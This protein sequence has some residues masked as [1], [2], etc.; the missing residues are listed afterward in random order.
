[1]PVNITTSYFVAPGPSPT[2]FI[3]TLGGSGY[4]NI[5]GIE[6]DS[7]NNIYVAGTTNSEGAGN[8][9]MFVAKYDTGGILQWQRALGG[10]R[11]DSAFSISIDPS[12]NIYV[13][14]RNGLPSIP[15][16]DLALIK[17]NTDGVLQWQRVL[18]NNIPQNPLNS[19][20]DSANNIY[21]VGSTG[22]ISSGIIAKYNSSGALQW[23]RTLSDGTKI[24]YW[25]VATDNSN[26]IYLTGVQGSGTEN[27]IMVKYNS[28]GVIQWQ[29]TFGTGSSIDVGWDMGIDASNNLYIVGY[30]TSLGTSDIYVAKFNSSGVVQWQK[31]INGGSGSDYGR[32]IVLNN[33]GDLFI[34]GNTLNVGSGSSD[35]FISKLSPSDGS[36]QWQRVLGG[37]GYDIGLNISLDS[38]ENYLQ[39]CGRTDT[40][41]AGGDDGM[42]CQLPA[43]GSGTGTYEVFTYQTSSLT[44]SSGSMSVTGTSFT[45]SAGSLTDSAGA[46][47][48]QVTT[49]T[50][51]LYP[52]TT[53]AMLLHM[54]NTTT[55]ETGNQTFSLSGGAT[56]ETTNK[57]GTHSLF[58]NG[59]GEHMRSASHSSDL[60]FGGNDF[61]VEAWVRIAAAPPTDAFIVATAGTG[62]TADDGWR[63][64]TYTNRYLRFSWVKAGNPTTG[65]FEQSTLLV[66]S[67]SAFHH[68]AVM[69]NGDDLVFALDGSV[70][71]YSSWF[72]D[73]INAGTRVT[74]IGNNPHTNGNH[75]NGYIDEV[76]VSTGTALY[77]S[78]YTPPAA[79][80]VV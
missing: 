27:T 21:L 71:T 72:D 17:Y 47:T 24:Q 13:T 28:S 74:G 1:M 44:D 37:A 16:M 19:T 67:D 39:I 56:F 50:D 60:E 77:T 5:S 42:V 80:F 25:G 64:W 48:D 31:V 10:T 58:Q 20:I 11:N 9:D 59:S 30:T 36:I 15:N 22:G 46:M 66:P 69:R 73:D 2:T 76:R 29:Q 61:T 23:H 70:D 41:G 26:N 52:L 35:T 32:Q 40:T 51:T 33:S 6:V 7:S 62:T 55:D 38:S 4:D 78:T 75:W 45:E 49:L 79:P 12:D 54:D 57:F 68:V 3:R 8:T 18:G 43:D 14:G 65:N 34:T 53:I 63:F